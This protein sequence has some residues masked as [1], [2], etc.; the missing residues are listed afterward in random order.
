MRW[1]CSSSITTL[2]STGILHRPGMPG[3][4]NRVRRRAGVAGHLDPARPRLRL[5][6]AVAN[7]TR[8]AD[9][10]RAPRNRAGD[11]GVDHADA[12]ARSVT[13]MVGRQPPRDLRAYAVDAAP[14]SREVFERSVG[15]RRLRQ[16]L[17][18]QSAHALH[19]DLRK[20]RPAAPTADQRE[21]LP[22]LRG[23][24]PVLEVRAPRRRRRPAPCARSSRAGFAPS[25][26]RRP[27]SA[28]PPPL[29][30]E[31]PRGEN[32][33]S[34]RAT[35]GARQASSRRGRLAMFISRVERSASMTDTRG[36]DRWKT[37]AGGALLHGGSA[38]LVA[39]FS[40]FTASL[41]PWLHEA[42]SGAHRGRCR[43]LP[44]RR[45]HAKGQR[46]PLPRDNHREPRR[47]GLRRILAREPPRV[48]G[49][50]DG[51]GRL[52]L[53]A[54]PRMLRACARSP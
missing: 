19:E 4:A 14:T 39:V 36:L 34:R 2:G 33:P 28:G 30:R 46:R 42:Y 45:L 11:G 9:G 22:P 52:L 24:A 48:R 51:L 44:R 23:V 1:I 20:R 15:E 12:L 6:R 7:A 10:R 41:V 13:A 21:P 3:S 49:V 35:A 25:P 50:R 16:I 29:P 47:L 32:S 31:R 8:R 26:R 5:R 38:A 37:S 53:P 40:Y 54:A 17:R 27:C 43:A 18:P